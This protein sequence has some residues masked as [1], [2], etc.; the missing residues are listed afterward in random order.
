MN[1]SPLKTSVFRGDSNFK[2]NPEDGPAQTFVKRCETYLKTPP[3]DT[4][5]GVFNLTAK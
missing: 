4:W 2:I 1:E 3:P 5:D